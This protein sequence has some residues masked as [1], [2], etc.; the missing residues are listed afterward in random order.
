MIQAK[1][2]SFSGSCAQ[3]SGRQ[4]IWI[5]ANELADI[6]RKELFD[7]EAQAADDNW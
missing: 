7:I 3:E 6:A 2:Q 1:K 5:D 4:D